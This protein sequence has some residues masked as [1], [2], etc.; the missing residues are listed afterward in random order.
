MGN[1]DVLKTNLYKS[2]AANSTIPVGVRRRQCET[3]TLPQTRSPVW[4][5]D[6]SSA[7]EKSRWIL[8][9]LQTGKSGNQEINAAIFDHCNL[10]N[11]QV[12]LDHSRYPS[13]DAATGFVKEH[14]AGVYKSFYDFA[15][16]NYVIDRLFAGSQEN[17]AASNSPV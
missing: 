12:C 10:T 2:I 7:P 16:R 17:P 6:V 8:V 9:G 13:A 5:L 4:R 15:C 11:M 3:F 1:T 14:Y